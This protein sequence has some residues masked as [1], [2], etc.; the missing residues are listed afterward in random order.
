MAGI[1]HSAVIGDVVDGA[2]REAGYN[3]KTVAAA[4]GMTE[5]TFSRR[6]NGLGGGFTMDEVYRIAAIIDISFPTIADRAVQALQRRAA[7]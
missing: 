3:H 1:N 5:R 7:A 6:V 2:I 4:V